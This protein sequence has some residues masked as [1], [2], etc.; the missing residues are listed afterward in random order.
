MQAL[1]DGYTIMREIGRLDNLKIAMIGALRQQLRC[2]QLRWVCVDGW[3]CGVAGC[4]A[5]WL[6]CGW[7][8]GL[9][10]AVIGA[11]RTAGCVA[12]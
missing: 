12:G 6:G 11:L 7:V 4:V 5:V 8:A 10:I 9:E 1:L 3:V 2:T